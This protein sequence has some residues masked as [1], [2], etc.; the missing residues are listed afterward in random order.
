MWSKKN[1]ERIIS[2]CSKK[3]PSL[4]AIGLS[5]ENHVATNLVLLDRQLQAIKA[6]FPNA[7][8]L[9]PRSLLKTFRRRPNFESLGGTQKDMTPST[10]TSSLSSLKKVNSTCVIRERSSSIVSF[11]ENISE[12]VPSLSPEEAQLAAKDE[13]IRIL[14]IESVEATSALSLNEP[15]RLLDVASMDIDPIPVIVK[16]AEVLTARGSY[17]EPS[18]LQVD[19]SENQD[20][21]ILFNLTDEDW[22]IGFDLET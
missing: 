16:S 13:V 15:N 14:G 6:S 20:D 11:Q 19:T 18:S 22:A 5:P 17:L 2:L 21:D 9:I 10:S 12:T 3:S 1:K 4:G 7:S 8:S